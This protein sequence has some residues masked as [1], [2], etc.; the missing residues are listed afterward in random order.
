MTQGDLNKLLPQLDLLSEV[1]ISRHINILFPIGR[2]A[3]LGPCS[4][5]ASDKPKAVLKAVGRGGMD[6]RHAAIIR[7][8]CQKN[9]RFLLKM[10]TDPFT[11]RQFMKE[12]N[13]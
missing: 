7:P 5:S 3:R 6:W 12:N 13:Q 10:Q 8:K 4:S 1:D 9:G 2:E 11:R